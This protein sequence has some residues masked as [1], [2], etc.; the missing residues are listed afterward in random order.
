MC[1]FSKAYALSQKE[2]ILF[3]PNAV[4]VIRNRKSR[5]NNQYNGQK[6]TDKNKHSSTKYYT[7]KN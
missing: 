1:Q 7:E 2:Y 4:G 6:I 3:H 5:K